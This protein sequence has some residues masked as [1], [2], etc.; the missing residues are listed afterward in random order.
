MWT[1]RITCPF[2][3]LSGACEGRCVL[4]VKLQVFPPRPSSLASIFMAL[5]KLRLLVPNSPCSGLVNSME[6]TLI[7]SRSSPWAL[8][9]SLM[10]L[11]ILSGFYSSVLLVNQFSSQKGS[12]RF[13][14]EVF[15]LLLSSHYHSL[16]SLQPSDK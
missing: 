15:F 12:P 11:T 5:V 9:S 8:G 1:G 14:C 6:K 13:S 2:E 4:E 16:L 10:P 7:A 3:G